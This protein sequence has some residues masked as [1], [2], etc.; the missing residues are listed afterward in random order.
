MAGVVRPLLWA[1]PEIGFLGPLGGSPGFRGYLPFPVLPGPT[2]G[3]TGA[4][5]GVF[6]LG[7]PAVLWDAL[8]GGAFR[9][10]PVAYGLSF[11]LL[12]H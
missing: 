10:G 3:L 4:H 2:R 9:A 8:R 1:C 11:F 6:S 7:T 12:R 5:T